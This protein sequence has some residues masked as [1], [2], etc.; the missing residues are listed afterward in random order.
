MPDGQIGLI[1]F[2]HSVAS[3]GAFDGSKPLRRKTRF[4]SRLNSI[5]AISR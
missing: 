3:N 5:G 1:D 4:V 2:A